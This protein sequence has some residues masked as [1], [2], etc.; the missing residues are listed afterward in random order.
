MKE[1]K[2][3]NGNNEGA[4]APRKAAKILVFENRKYQGEEFIIPATD[5]HGHSERIFFRIQPGLMRDLKVVVA[6]NKFPF[7]TIGDV[8]RLATKMMVELL[9]SLEPIPSVNGQVN[10]IIRI[11]RDEEM[12]QEFVG[13]FEQ[14]GRSINRYISAGEHGQARRMLVAIRDEIR[15]M[16]KGYW[17]KKYWTELNAKFGHLMKGGGAKLSDGIEDEDDED[18]D[19]KTT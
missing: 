6:S 8:G 5:T 10:A 15:G 11:V 19:L 14:V 1:M 2:Q 3:G 13:T 16:P 9:Q 4:T 12:H 7:R 17:R 18:D